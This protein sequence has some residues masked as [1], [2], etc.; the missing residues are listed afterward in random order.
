MESNLCTTFES[1]PAFIT[2]PS[3][4]F[5]VPVSTAQC[6]RGFSTQNRI[7]C[8]T[9]NRLKTKHLD[10]LVR[11]SEEGPPIDDFSFSNAVAKFLK[12]KQRRITHYH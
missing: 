11:I 8:K 9:R 12:M 4:C 10:I 5:I 2:L 7:K 3:A 6:E 1:F